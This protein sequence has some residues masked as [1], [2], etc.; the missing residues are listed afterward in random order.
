M[1][2]SWSDLK[3]TFLKEVQAGTTDGEA[4]YVTVLLFFHSSDTVEK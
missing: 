2:L 1:I 4:L 3:D